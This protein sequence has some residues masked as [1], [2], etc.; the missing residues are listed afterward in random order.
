MGDVILTATTIITMND[1][2]PR[3]QAV[4]VSSGRIVA[5]GSL[6]DCRAALPGAEVVDTGVAALAP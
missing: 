4:A 1:S 5:V 2:A 6:D 3:A